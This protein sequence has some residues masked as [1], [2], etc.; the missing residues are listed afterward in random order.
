MLPGG[1]KF[2]KLN[3]SHAIHQIPL[4]E[5]SKRYVI[6]NTHTGLFTYRVATIFRCVIKPDHTLLQRI[7]EGLL[8][9]TTPDSVHGA[10]TAR[11]CCSTA[12]KRKMHIHG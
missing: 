3:L 12:Q 10:E 5:E 11:G 1:Q 9:G 6:I 8:Q 7:K 2:T 4:D